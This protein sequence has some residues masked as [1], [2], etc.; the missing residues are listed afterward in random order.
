MVSLEFWGNKT[1]ESATTTSQRREPI[2]VLKSLLKL[3]STRRHDYKR[4][5]FES[6]VICYDSAEDYSFLRTICP[7]PLRSDIVNRIDHRGEVDN[8]SSETS[9]IR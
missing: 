8:E 5:L 7:K 6:K 1:L 2:C 4:D 9:N 3:S